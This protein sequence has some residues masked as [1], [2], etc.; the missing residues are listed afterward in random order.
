MELLA[1]I[2]VHGLLLGQA[3]WKQ[4]LMQ[5][6]YKCAPTTGGSWGDH[7]RWIFLP[8]KKYAMSRNWEDKIF[9][10]LLRAWTKVQKVLGYDVPT[11]EEEYLQQHLVWNPNMQLLLGHML[12]ART[13]LD[14]AKFDVGIGASIATWKCF[15]DLPFHERSQCLFSL[16]GRH[17]ICEQVQEVL[18][19]LS[20]IGWPL[21]PAKWEGAFTTLQV[22]VGVR[23]YQVNGQFLE[24]EM[25]DD[26]VIRF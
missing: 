13:K 19:N 3:P 26:G 10:G 4:L 11:S 15:Y 20:Y 14:W 8:N 21:Q 1:K 12:G 24:Y 7:V 17:I 2:V 25:D 22:L 23:G 5:R 6:L 9:N 16:R 18:G